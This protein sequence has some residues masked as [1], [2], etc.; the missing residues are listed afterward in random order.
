MQIQSGSGTLVE[1]IGGY[2][3]SAPAL[4]IG[5]AT[6]AAT[7]AFL[8]MDAM[9]KLL[10]VQPVIEAMTRLGYHPQV[11]F[12]LGITLSVC[13]L[14]YV[15]PRTAVL[16]AVLLTGY[17]GGAIATH[18]RVGSPLLTHVLFPAYLAAFIWGSLLL[19]DARLRAFVP[20]G[21]RG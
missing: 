14:L 19:R 4:W 8:A 2:T 12:G 6:G 18:V 7:V 9:G 11:A 15:V 13:L 16:G 17:L 21:R 10:E 1:T 3:G 20:W 5:W